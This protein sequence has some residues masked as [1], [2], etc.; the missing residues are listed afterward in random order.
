MTKRIL[1]LVLACLL[2]G[3]AALA[4]VTGPL[5]EAERMSDSSTEKSGAFIF[6]QDRKEGLV[7][8]SG[9][10]LAEAQFGDLS[11]AGEGY[12]TATNENGFNTSALVNTS[13]E[14]LTPFEYSDFTVV[15][16]NWAVGV[17]LEGTDDRDIA[18]YSVIFGEN[19]YATIVRNDVFYL[20]E[21]K[22]AGSLERKQFSRAREA[23]GNGW[24]IVEDRDGGITAYDADF[25]AA[26]TALT[27][28][29]DA[30]LVVKSE[31]ELSPK[32]LYSAVTGEKLADREY[33]SL[34]TIGKGFTSF[35]DS[36]ARLY[37]IL[38]AAGEEVCP[39]A[40]ST[41]N[42]SLLGGHYV[43]VT[44]NRED[45]TTAEGLLDLDTMALAVPCLY[46]RIYTWGDKAPINDGYVC[47]EQEGKLGFIDLEGNVTCPIQYAKDSVSYYGCTLGATDM[48]GA[49][50]IVA[51]DGT[52]TPLEGVT[53]LSLKNGLTSSDGYFLTVKNADGTQG[54]VDWHG[55]QVVDFVLDYSAAVYAGDCLFT[56]TS[57]YK[58]ER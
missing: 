39:P 55:T 24:L 31:N 34:S 36:D 17:V 5:F 27:S 56:G 16:P 51:A 32:A 14:A 37:G 43:K 52:V 33:G 57:V 25:N 11:Y 48:T 7:D 9:N 2:L 42:T 45:N 54:V 22:L 41:I 28:M 47:V 26:E 30:E 35:Y 53:E 21:K 29:Y 18:D 40:Y 50:T 44:Q 15:S 38:N 13:G 8:L 12:Y 20:P 1:A 6:T 10:V 3:A 49:V 23:G 58:I 4:E 46:E 19:D